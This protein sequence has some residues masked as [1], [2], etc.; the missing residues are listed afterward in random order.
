MEEV[1]PY[2]PYLWRN[3]SIIIADTVTAWDFDQCDGRPG[4][5]AR[6]SRSVE[7]ATGLGE[8]KGGAAPVG[9][10]PTFRRERELR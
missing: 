1:V 8:M 7:A 9:A 10:A 2:V 5:G 3:R 4:V 6:R